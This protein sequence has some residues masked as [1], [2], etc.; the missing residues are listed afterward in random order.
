[1]ARRT[2][3][4]PRLY[5]APYSDLVFDARM[6]ALREEP[7][8]EGRR[9]EHDIVLDLAAMHLAG[10]PELRLVGDQPWELVCGE[11]VPYRLR[12]RSAEWLQRGGV[13]A[14]FD[15]LPPDDDARRLF[16]LVHLRDASS[17]PRYVF[18]TDVPTGAELALRAAGCV[19]EQREGSIEQVEYL[20]RWSAAPPTPAR[21]V[22][23]PAKLHKR[24]G[25]DPVRIRLLGRTLD[26]RLFIGG[27]PHQHID[28][29][30]VDMVVNLSGVENPWALLFGRHPDDHFAAKQ[31]MR[32][33][34]T[35]ADLAAEARAVVEE[36]RA[37]KRVL[38]HCAAGIN[39]SSSLCCASLMLLEGLGPPAALARVRRAHPEAHPDPYHWFALQQLERQLQAASRRSRGRV[40]G[41]QGVPA[42]LRVALGVG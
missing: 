42:H 9:G 4:H 27:M 41:V 33:G 6:E 28:R 40:A 18:V 16:Y 17:G 37:G 29:P 20:R 12:F 22:P 32:L 36:L 35:S 15:A 3:W 31:E 1:M 8:S 2:A 25:G 13:Y 39:R 19:L 30:D 7:A 38:V 14:A 11:R 21:L 26:S 23:R 34:M 10:K 24:Y 5:P